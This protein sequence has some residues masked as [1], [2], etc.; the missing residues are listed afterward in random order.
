MKTK[1]AVIFKDYGFGCGEFFDTIKEC[2]DWAIA[3]NKE[4]KKD[5]IFKKS[6]MPVFSISKIEYDETLVKPEFDDYDGLKSVMFVP[7]VESKITEIVSGDIA[8]IKATKGE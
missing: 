3:K 5:P 7:I 6:Y 4:I 8:S 1:Y 2:R